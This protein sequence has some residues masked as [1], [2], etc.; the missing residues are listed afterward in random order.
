MYYEFTMRIIVTGANGFVGAHVV[1][2]LL[3]LGIHEV[4]AI[5]NL[6]YGPW[7]F[8]SKEISSFRSDTTDLRNRER[9]ETIVGE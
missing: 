9:V 1:R 5:D 4:L 3:E 7:R 2:Q 8:S 6:R